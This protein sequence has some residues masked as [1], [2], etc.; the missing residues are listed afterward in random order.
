MRFTRMIIHSM[1][2]LFPD[3]FYHIP[4]TGSRLFAGLFPADS[5]AGLSEV[6]RGDPSDPRTRQRG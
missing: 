6:A 4:A 2:R 3:R 5:A 1:L